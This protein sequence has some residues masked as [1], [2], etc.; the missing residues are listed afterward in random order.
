[1]TGLKTR[2]ALRGRPRS[3]LLSISHRRSGLPILAGSGEQA[4]PAREGTR[5][6]AGCPIGVKSTAAPPVMRRSCRTE[7][8]NRSHEQ[9][10]AGPEAVRP[11]LIPARRLKMPQVWPGGTQGIGH[12]GAGK[13]HARRC[14][15]RQATMRGTMAGRP[16]IVP[17]T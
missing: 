14:F 16:D 1:M 17:T 5:H 8:C 11:D 15:F 13:I 7:A 2:A 9:E 10:H 6:L 4:G 3:F 12:D